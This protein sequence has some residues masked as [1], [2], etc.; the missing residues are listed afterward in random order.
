ATCR[1]SRSFLD[2]RDEAILRVLI[3]TGARLSEVGGLTLDDV[4]LDAMVLS[5]RGKRSRGRERPR[6][7]PFGAKTAKALDR[8]VTS[9]RTRHYAAGKTDA[10]W[11]GRDG[12][13]TPN[14]V[15]QAV[16]SR[17]VAAGLPWLHAHAL[18]HR[19]N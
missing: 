15:A 19:F 11:L 1:R 2:A 9:F 12:E 13:M 18:R 10:L 17:G 14:G 6:L 7:V 16:K 8:Y 3:D 5:V 4:S